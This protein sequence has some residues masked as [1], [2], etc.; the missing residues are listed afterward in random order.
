MGSADESALLELANRYATIVDE[1][2]FTDLAQVF[3][4][5][6]VLE[7]GRGRRDGLPEIVAAM[8]GLHRYDRTD[9]RVLRSQV[10][11]E[12]TTATGTVDCEAH[13]WFTEAGTRRDHQMEITYHDRY[14]ATPNGWRLSHRRLEIHRA[15]TVDVD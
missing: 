15:E 8:Q 5:D 6:A 4:A 2:R 3:T 13:H 12:P 10:S 14:L 11:V 7:T 9:H 1:R